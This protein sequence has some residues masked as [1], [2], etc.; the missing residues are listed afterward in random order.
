MKRI[1]A[2]HDISGIGKC[3]LTAAL[4]I[5]SSCGIE[6]NPVPTAVLSTHTGEFSGYS[7]R[8]LTSDLESYINHWKTL[9]IEFDGI[10]SGYLGSVSQIKIVEDFINSFSGNDTIV[11]VDPAMADHNK[12][13]SGFDFSYVEEMKKLC[14][15]A[16]IITPNV[17]EAFLLAGRKSVDLNQ[18]DKVTDCLT[19]ISNRY[20]II[21]DYSTDQAKTGCIIIDNKNNTKKTIE[22]KR[23]PGIYYGTGDIFSSVIIS[24]LVSG[25]DIF[26]AA[27][28]A[29]DF[30]SASIKE[31]YEEK[32]DT[33]FGIH[34][35]KNIPM[36]INLLGG[37]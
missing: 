3:S 15:T 7:F 10:F 11:L 4:P 33:R 28:I 25:K 9:G 22:A 19:G 35:E 23:Y 36:L 6:C 24:A 2:I 12:L 29:T 17:T 21:T 27:E 1:A 34:F 13:Y 8:D 20:A 5:I 16:D 31:T 30:I 18:I 37:K 26:E 14:G 32:T